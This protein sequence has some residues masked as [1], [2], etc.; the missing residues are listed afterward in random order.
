MRNTSL[1]KAIIGSSTAKGGFAN[2]R[3]IA[4][5]FNNYKWDTDAQLWLRYMGYEPRFIKELNA[6]VVPVRISLKDVVKFGLDKDKILEELKYKKSDVQVRIEML[7]KNVYFIEN[8]SV[9]KANSDADYNQVDKRKV[10]EYR[11]MWNFD[12]Q[13]A[14][15][16]KYF[17]GELEPPKSLNKRDREGYFLTK[18]Q[19]KSEVK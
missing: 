15:W 4:E 5:K 13:I 7:Y 14:T 11:N 10:D 17:T 18:C 6:E 1:N 8:I 3:T 16:L 12:E 9:K 2:E 19:R